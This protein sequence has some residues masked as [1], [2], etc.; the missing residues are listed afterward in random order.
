[1]PT[2]AHDVPSCATRAHY[3]LGADRFKQ[4]NACTHVYFSG[5]DERRIW[6]LEGRDLELNPKQTGAKINLLIVAH[7]EVD[8]RPHTAFDRVVRF[9]EK[10]TP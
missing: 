2:S 7:I 8:G 6:F 3:D 10:R 9:T 1:M 4:G 5:L